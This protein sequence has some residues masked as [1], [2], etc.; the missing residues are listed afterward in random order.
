MTMSRDGRGTPG[1]IVLTNHQPKLRLADVLRRRKTTLR[2]FIDS[3]GL[4]TYTALDIMCGR[5]GVIAPTEVEFNTARPITE[6]VN[7]PQEG[8]I[9]LE[10]PPLLDEATGLVVNEPVV[11]RGGLVR[12]ADDENEPTESPQKKPRKKKDSQTTDQ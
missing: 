11:P 12:L 9:V 8:I 3:L 7:S 2:A 1:R 5:L 6:R 4:T 10:A